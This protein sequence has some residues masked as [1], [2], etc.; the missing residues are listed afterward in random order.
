[1]SF[2]HKQNR[3]GNLLTSAI[4]HSL[5]PRVGLPSPPILTPTSPRRSPLLF[6]P[7]KRIQQST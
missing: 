6:P 5:I 7:S 4:Y 3:T 2:R 1:M